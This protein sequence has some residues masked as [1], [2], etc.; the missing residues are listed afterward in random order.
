MDTSLWNKF[1]GIKVLPTKKKFFGQYLYKVVVK[2]EGCRIA[3]KNKPSDIAGLVQR[4]INENVELIE[5]YKSAWGGTPFRA[6]IALSINTK[7]L[8]YYA[9]VREK[10][11]DQ[12]K[13]RVEE[14]RLTIY[15]ND[16]QLLFDIVSGDHM[17][18]ILEIY[19]P[20]NASDQ[21]ALDNG[22][23]LVGYKQRY[24]YKIVLKDNINKHPQLPQMYD[25]LMALG[26]L[27]KLPPS[28]RN[29]FKMGGSRWWYPSTFFYAMDEQTA[30]YIQLL[31]PQG[32][33]SGIYKLTR[34][35]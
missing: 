27:V 4:R 15:C 21:Q 32:T 13:Y 11:A 20:R 16:E 12:I 26:E 31:M 23:L 35:Y 17:G 25:Q 14:P 33:V 1:D 19:R 28:C 10:Y 34:T 24:Q 9:E 3:L 18:Y 29:L 6:A 5:R 22:D 30:S 2:A 8:E 7:Q